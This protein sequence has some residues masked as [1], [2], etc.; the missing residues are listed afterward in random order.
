MFRQRVVWISFVFSL[1]LHVL[2]VYV[3]FVAWQEQDGL[4]AEAFKARLV[5]KKRFVPQQFSVGKPQELPERQM[6]YLKSDARPQ[7]IAEERLAPP[8]PTPLAFEVPQAPSEL[9]P[10]EA[11][12]KADTVEI[13]R[14]ELVRP[15]QMPIVGSLGGEASMDL[16]R[17]EDMARANKDHGLIVPDLA[18]KRDTK[19]YV[20][21]TRLRTYGA[22]SDTAGMLDDLAR[23]MRD[24]SYILTRVRDTKY[25]YFLSEQ[26]LKDP[27]HFLFEGGGLIPYND[28]KKTYFSEEEYALMRRYLLEAGGFLFI[29]GGYRYLGEM[30]GHLQNILG[31]NARMVEVAPSHPIYHSFYDFD[32]GFPGEDKQRDNSNLPGPAWYYPIGNRTDPVILEEQI[33]NPEFEDTETLPLLGIWGVE[34]EGELVALLSDLSLHLQWRE[35]TEEQD[36]DAY[37]PVVSLM[38]GT[39]IVVYALTRGNGL[40]P[41]IDKPVWERGRPRVAVAGLE[42]EVGAHYEETLE[43]ETLFEVLDASL[44]LIQSPF[45]SI[46]E[47]NGVQI[48]LDGRYSLDLFKRGVNGLVMH[49]VPAG[50]HWIELQYGGKSKQLEVDLQGGKVLTVL[51]GLNRLAFLTQLRLKPQEDLVGL[52][53]WQQSFDDLVIEEVFLGEDQELLE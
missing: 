39:N 40:T 35:A 3:V 18:S 19:G 47:K 42:P 6:E 21:F 4:D 53:V 49:N 9:N 51:F 27:I 32:G 11:G 48:S 15:D 25:D 13:A 14:T 38:A 29:E 31:G 7:E 44:A 52:P 20:N 23:Y 37:S 50:R 36:I 1:L 33:F 46:I 5:L 26:L 22:G 16:L 43:D 28:D 34:V 8:P 2:G 12:V 10:Y 24:Y 17:I 41:K 45:G 30:K